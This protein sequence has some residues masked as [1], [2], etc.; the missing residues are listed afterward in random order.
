M[1]QELVEQL[2][3][4]GESSMRRVG[5]ARDDAAARELEGYRIASGAD[6]LLVH[7]FQKTRYQRIDRAVVGVTAVAIAARPST[8]RLRTPVRSRADRVGGALHP[9]G[10]GQLFSVYCGQ[11]EI[12]ETRSGLIEFEPYRG[13]A[14]FAAI[15]AET[16][17]HVVEQPRDSILGICDEG[18]RRHRCDV[19]YLEAKYARPARSR[20]RR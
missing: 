12:A 17:G 8:D 5:A 18:G 6:S 7:D 20:L 10:G 2:T 16:V 19:G 1:D 14:V 9:T 15:D 13:G 4:L 11:R 3:D